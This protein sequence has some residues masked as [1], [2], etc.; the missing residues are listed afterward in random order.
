[1]AALL[2]QDCT[3]KPK[4]NQTTA[5]MIQVMDS[6]GRNQD[7]LQRQQEY[8]DLA[9]HKRQLKAREKDADCTFKPDIG[10]SER[11]V[12]AGKYSQVGESVGSSVRIR[13]SQRLI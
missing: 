8:L 11:V 12:A 1:M 7:F 5:R 6:C 9:E 3:F 2:D 13:S 4:I 10:N